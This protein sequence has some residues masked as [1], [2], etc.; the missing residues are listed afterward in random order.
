MSAKPEPLTGKVGSASAKGKLTLPEPRGD[1][2]LM[3]GFSAAA[4]IISMIAAFLVGRIL[5]AWFSR[6]R[7][8]AN[9]PPC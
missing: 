3:D 6:S 7:S 2:R 8:R 9:P 5:H 4:L 1:V